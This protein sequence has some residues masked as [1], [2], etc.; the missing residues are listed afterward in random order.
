MI[1]IIV[2]DIFPTMRATFDAMVIAVWVQPVQWLMFT[3]RLP[4]TRPLVLPAEV[5][6]GRPKPTPRRAL[7]VLLDLLRYM[8][9]LPYAAI[10]IEFANYP[11]ILFRRRCRDPKDDTCCEEPIEHI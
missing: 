11:T 7:A 8:N 2:F 6:F 9:V 4:T 10:L 3:A 5:A 1:Q